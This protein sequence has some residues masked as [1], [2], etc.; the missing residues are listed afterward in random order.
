[1]HPSRAAEQRM[2]VWQN[3]PRWEGRAKNYRLEIFM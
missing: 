1:L 2:T 3:G